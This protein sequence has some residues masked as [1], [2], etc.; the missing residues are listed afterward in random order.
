MAEARSKLDE[1]RE[2]SKQE[3]DRLAVAVDNVIQRLHEMTA[4]LAPVPEQ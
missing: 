3:R 1:A 4:E 2:L